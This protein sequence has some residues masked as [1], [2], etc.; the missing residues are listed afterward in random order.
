MDGENHTL[1]DGLPGFEMSREELKRLRRRERNRKRMADP[2]YREWN[3]EY[4]KEYHRKR[5][6]DPAYRKRIADP[7]Y[8]ERKREYAKEYYRKRAADPAYRKRTPA[9]R[10]RE[11]ERQRELMADPA[12]RERKRERNRKSKY[13]LTASEHQDYL[14]KQKGVCAICERPEKSK[15]KYGATASLAVDHCHETEE[16]HGMKFAVRGLLCAE[17]NKV[18]ARA[19][20]HRGWFKKAFQYIA[21]FEKRLELKLMAAG[22]EHDPFA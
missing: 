13:G 12:Y 4:Q 11:R 17:C 3:R 8:R 2:A 5:T 6:A 19:T 18:L 21:A 10:E 1:F 20:A 15:N 16:A 9:Y 7:A 22:I 14:L